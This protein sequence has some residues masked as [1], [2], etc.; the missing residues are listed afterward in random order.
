MLF[1]KQL[2]VIPNPASSETQSPST[3][4]FVCTISVYNRV[5]SSNKVKCNGKVFIFV[6]AANEG[7]KSNILFDKSLFYRSF[8]AG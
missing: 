3:T 8:M 4:K 5:N 1:S 2:I 6:V 7:T